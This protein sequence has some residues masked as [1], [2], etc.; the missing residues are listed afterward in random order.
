[1]DLLKLD[2]IVF[3]VI[4]HSIVDGFLSRHEV[5]AIS[6]DLDPLQ[7]LPGEGCK[8]FVQVI[9][10][11][12]NAVGRDLDIYCLTAGSTHDLMDHD[13]AIGCCITFSLRTGS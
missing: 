2:Q 8:H 7:R 6:I 1:M 11:A 10:H 13:F 5:I 4:D 9:L 12:A 3:G